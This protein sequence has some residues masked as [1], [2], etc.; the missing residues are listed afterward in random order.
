[1]CTSAHTFM[2][3]DEQY[4]NQK[5]KNLLFV[6]FLHI[7]GSFFLYKDQFFSEIDVRTI[8]LTQTVLKIVVEALMWCTMEVIYKKRFVFECFLDRYR[9]EAYNCNLR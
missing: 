8:I 5:R 7:A 6:V 3:Q 2:R 1:M 4:I 9:I